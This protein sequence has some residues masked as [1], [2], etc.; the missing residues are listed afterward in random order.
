[1]VGL[2]ASELA[3]K[4]S[5]LSLSFRVVVENG[6]SACIT[7]SPSPH[8]LP[9]GEG[10]THSAFGVFHAWDLLQRRENDAPHGNAFPRPAGEG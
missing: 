6:P 9:L 8:P 3:Q 7:R 2:I 4:P 10:A 1:M 5:Q